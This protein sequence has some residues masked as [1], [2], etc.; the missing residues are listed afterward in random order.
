MIFLKKLEI[1]FSKGVIRLL[2]VTS[3]RNGSTIKIPE[4]AKVLLLRQDRIGD[5][6]ISTAIVHALAKAKPGWRLDM[7]F[8]QS[9]TKVL[10]NDPVIA[11]RWLYDKKIGSTIK[12]IRSLRREHYDIVIDLMDN[13]S[14]T[15]TSLLALVGGAINVGLEKN[16]GFVYDILVPMRPRSTTHILDR[17]ADMLPPLGVTV[18]DGTLR[19]SYTIGSLARKKA[20]D[21]FS[22]Y[23]ANNKIFCCVNTSAG[24]EERFW[25]EEKYREFLREAISRFPGIIFFVAAQPRDARRAQRICEGI[26]GTHLLP[27]SSSYDE[28]AALVDETD[29]VISPDTSVVHLGSALNKAQVTLFSNE[30]NAINWS[31]YRV[32]FRSV[33][34]HDGD[35][36]NIAPH[37]VIVALEDLLTENFPKHRPEIHSAKF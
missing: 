2:R 18:E 9:N 4:N 11:K 32:Q 12:L 23:R 35:L 22:S 30:Y 33:I 10:D 16:N 25:G 7:L 27:A 37:D 29:I 24:A 8:G 17:L 36:R 20:S 5:V 19:L 13:S 28:F 31:P 15:S 34:S 26:P 21:F 1:A 14:A 3:A 6:L